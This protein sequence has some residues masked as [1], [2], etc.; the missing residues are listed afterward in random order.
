[1]AKEKPAAGTV[2][3]KMLV[4]MVSEANDRTRNAVVYVSPAEAERLIEKG[5]AEKAGGSPGR[6]S[7]A[8]AAGEG[9]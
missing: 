5:F 8:A 2:P 1:M 7:K 3:V 6:P 9:E 4:S